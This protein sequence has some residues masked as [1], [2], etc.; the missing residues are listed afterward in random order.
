MASISVGIKTRICMIS[1]THTA[2]PFSASETTYAYRSPLPKAD[3]L[4]HGG[5]LTKVG[6]SAEHKAMV[7]MLKAADAELK[8]VIAG[9]H[10]IT[11]DEEHFTDFGYRRHRRPEWFGGRDIVLDEDEKAIL[12]AI[13]G[14]EPPR[15]EL[16]R[17]YVQRMKDIY[18]DDSARGAGIRYLEEGV[19]R[20]TLSSGAKL[21]VYASP[22]QP[23]YGAWAF[24]Y[25][26]SEDRFNLPVPGSSKPAPA[27]PVPDYPDIDIMLTHGP[28]ANVM[29]SVGL[30]PRHVRQVGCEHLLRAACR[31]RPRLYVFGHIHE[32]WGARRGRW[33]ATAPDG[34]RQED[35]PTDTDDILDRRAAFCD[36]SS[37]GPQPLRLGEET[38]FVNASIMTLTYRP[39]N[40]PWLV[41]ID[42]P[43]ADA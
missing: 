16:M 37:S 30:D 13:R 36:V 7:Q 23:M 14:D 42:L 26:R 21:T 11:L 40:A 15:K 6:Y 24:G 20:F 12:S 1:D 3:V 34:I 22:Y 38:L 4:I 31:A 10:D 27:N 8:L 19:H 28:P 17:N 9:N 39:Y 25:H 5:D 2:S 43:S 29:D 18:T 41:D 32:G 33:D 35:V